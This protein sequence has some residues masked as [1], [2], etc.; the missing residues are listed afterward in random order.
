MEEGYWGTFFSFQEDTSAVTSCVTTNGSPCFFQLLSKLAF[1][2]EHFQ[3]K[4]NWYVFLV[5]F[6]TMFCTGIKCPFNWKDT[7]NY[8]SLGGFL[9]QCI[10]FIYLHSRQ[11]IKEQAAWPLD[12]CQK[13]QLCNYNHQ[14]DLLLH[15]QQ[16]TITHKKR[17][18]SSLACV[19]NW[20]R[21][22]NAACSQ[23]TWRRLLCEPFQT[24]WEPPAEFQNCS[25]Q[26]SAS[27][28][29]Q[30]C[31]KRCKNISVA[32]SLSSQTQNHVS[33]VFLQAP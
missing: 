11:I 21:S 7:L 8:Y 12:N 28:S 30:F 16:L 4:P 27:S 31:Q 17:E 25:Q 5:F 29:S 23:S 14:R 20:A 33:S 9:P 10:S 13:A 1:F 18:K 22:G 24:I 2:R 15:I 32:L 6:Y 19:E 26:C 3:K